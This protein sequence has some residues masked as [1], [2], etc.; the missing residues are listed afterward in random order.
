MSRNQDEIEE[1]Q[2]I[3]RLQKGLQDITNCIHASENT[4]KLII[5]S[6]QQIMDLLNVETSNIYIIDKNRKEIYTILQVDSQVMYRRLA[7]DNKTIPG[8]VVNTGKTINLDHF[9][10]ERSLKGNFKDPRLSK[11][12]DNGIPI[13]QILA[14][15]IIYNGELLG[16]IEIIN[17][18]A[19][20]STF[21]DEDPV[22]LQ[23]I[24]DV[25]GIALYNQQRMAPQ[26]RK[27]KFSYLVNNELISKE[28][29]SQARKES[30][31]AKIPLEAVLMKTYSIKKEDIGRSLEDYHRCKFIPFDE[32]T[33]LPGDLLKNLNREYLLRERWVPIEKIGED[34]HIIMDD[35]QNILKRDAIENLLKTKAIKY[36]ISLE[37]D[38]IKYI[39]L[40]FSPETDQSSF[41][42][43]LEKLETGDNTFDADHDE[44]HEEAVKESDSAIIQLVNKIINDAFAR[45]ASDIHI[46]P[47]INEKNVLVR[48]RIDGS[49]LCYQTLPY[50]YRAAIVSRIKIMSN[51]NITVK[52]MP[53][54]GK[55]TMKRQ[56]RE[57][58][59]LRVA[60]I[61]TQGNVEDIVMR[62]LAKGDTLPLEA[63]GMTAQNYTSLVNA[64][65]KPYG[66]ILV[67]GPTGSG[68]T[69]TL[70]AV[71]HYIN[72]PERKIWTA[73]D[74]VEI[75]QYGL[76]QVQVQPKIG[77]DFAAAMRSFL[78][79]DPD[80]I[81]VGEMRD[82]ET[83][84]IGVEASLTGHLVLSTLHTNSA[85]ETITRLLDM[86]V[87]PLNFSDS[88]LGILAQR[89][90]KKL[91]PKCKE[92]YHPS[93]EEYNELVENY[94]VDVFSRINVPYSKDLM[95]YRAKGCD[96][97]EKSGYKGR[98]GL[99]ELLLNSDAIKKSIYRRESI[100]T[101]R[102]LAMSE[103]MNTL[104]QDGIAKVFQGVTDVKQVHRV[105]TR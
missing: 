99:Y 38:I 91:C 78:R 10:N 45:G 60:T 98:M 6:R 77:F 29:L 84:K 96:A 49:C 15:P 87:D 5:D 55:I 23:E 56:G 1:L 16:M 36:N 63:M 65:E 3:L 74:P 85:P 18:I 57:D 43:I 82:T 25:L 27:T 70:H 24:I 79:A 32:K 94:G 54:D 89:L 100:E 37:D 51:L 68:K 93:Q 103:G 58:I 101:L 75:T 67:V 50:S 35:P 9:D 34:V 76:R 86:G 8:Y 20:D 22:L 61:P 17:K 59:E 12:E 53:Q 28:T 73:E 44:D 97:C 52:R 31:S 81:M 95:L 83:A 88:V 92:P 46:E 40:F 2:D 48:F 19:N 30:R 71:L 33:P 41:S 64:C 11:S 69:T 13:R 42:D 90:V 102:D 21:E 66:L 7:I 72:K 39:D 62:I 105:C 26:A 104:Y 14:M 47:N 4:R 80:V